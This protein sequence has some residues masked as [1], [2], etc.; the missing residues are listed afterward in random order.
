MPL[1]GR[2]EDYFDPGDLS[3]IKKIAAIGD[4]YS[5]GIGAGEALGSIIQAASP[6]SD[7]AC[8]RYAGAYP[9]YVYKDPRFGDNYPDFQFLSCSGAKIDDVLN[10]Q[11]PDLES[12]QQA[13]ML[14]VGGNDAELKNIL[15]SCVFQWGVFNPLQ[16]AVGE[17]AKL[18]ENQFK[19][20]AKYIDFEAKAR[21]CEGQLT[22]TNS[23]I[24]SNSFRS[25]LDRVLSA[26]KYKLAKGGKIYMTGYARF[27]DEAMTSECDKVTWAV[28]KFVKELYNYRQETAYLTTPRRK[29]MNVLVDDINEELA[30]AAKRA[31]DDVIFVNYDK[32]VGEFGGRFCGPGID[33]SSEGSDTRVGLMFYEPGTR[34]NKDDNPWKRSLGDPMND[35]FRGQVNL[36]VLFQQVLEPDV[37]WKI[38]QANSATAT[39]SARSALEKRAFQVPD[40]TPDAYGR[41][42]HPQILL[43]QIISNLVMWHMMDVNAVS[44]GHQALPEE[45][46]APDS[47]PIGYDGGNQNTPAPGDSDAPDFYARILPLGASIVWGVGSSNGNGFR[48]PLRD[49][50]RQAGWKVNMNVEAKSGDRVDE[51]QVKSRSSTRFQP[52]IIVINAGTNDCD[53]NHDIPGFAGRYNA[54]LDELYDAI[55]GV[56]II[57][58]T[59]LPSCKASIAANRDAVNSQIKQLVSARRSKKEKIVLADAENPAGYFTTADL[60]SD[61]IHPHDSGHRKFAG[62]LGRAIYEAKAAG[63]L[64]KPKDTGISD[65]A[66]TIDENANHCEKTYGSGVSHGPFNTQQGN[67]LDDGLYTHKSTKK[68][69]L[70]EFVAPSG[71]TLNFARFTNKFGNHDLVFIGQDDEVDKAKG[72]PYTVHRNNGEG[73]DTE[74]T[75]F[76]MSDACKGR[77]VRFVDVNADGLDDMVCIGQNGDAFVSINQGKY[78]FKWM[79]DIWKKNEGPKQDRVRLPDI[80]GDG[81]ADYCTIADNGDTTC[82][83]NGGQGDMPEYWQPL[84]VMFLG[85]GKG[86]IAGVRFADLNGDS[87]DDWMWV[88]DT[89]KTWTYLNNRKCSKN[90][91]KPQWRP[92]TGDNLSGLTHA[93][94]GEEVGRNFIQFARVYGDPQDFG[95]EGRLDY[96]WV[97]KGTRQIPSGQQRWSLEVWKNEGSGA[98]KLKADGS[99]YC[100]MMGHKNGAMDYVWVHSTGYTVL[101]ESLGGQFPDDPPYWGPNREIWRAETVWG[102]K[103]DRRDLHLADWDGDGLCDIIYVRPDTN[104]M[105]VWLN[106]YKKN[107]DFGFW[108]HIS[109]TGPTG[110]YKRCEEHRGV[111]IFDLAVRFADIDGDGRADYLC[112]EPNGRVWGYLNKGDNKL[113]LQSQIKYSEGKDRA[114]LRWADVD[115][116]GKADMLWVDKF[117]GDAT[118][119][120]NKGQKPAS[121]STFTWELRGKAYMGAAQGQCEHW[122]DL[123]GDGRA[124][125]HVVDSI[126]NTAQTW[127]NVCPGGGSTSNGD[128]DDTLKTPPLTI[129]GY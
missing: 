96:I 71:F 41:V 57:A 55:P 91:L 18:F 35:T 95:L 78:S 11:I 37:Q 3:H 45:L 63:F 15:N 93:G 34:E 77:G 100:N 59:V 48:K 46:P 8:S 68:G 97:K 72:R 5:A 126:T 2:D 99:R 40:I 9:Y 23:I 31:G 60:T 65:D 28:W 116:D 38:D 94:M 83:R 110:S 10:D 47:C 86:D 67:G 117:D 69:S 13:I 64:S 1:L 30:A 129:P 51:I 89:G 49:G 98:T 44:N 121:G 6:K 53:Q 26:A 113:E 104:T 127:F 36:D 73:W 27:W 54:M 58:S 20:I 115:G 81:R 75:T 109:N 87:R 112:I 29:L 122:P 16:A 80:D 12:G 52:N 102:D 32:Y 106:Q 114:N 111:G 82:W 74:S 76:W 61:C 120:Y 33:E 42:F 24:T 25:K 128:D 125:M 101:Y 108:E 124:D 70:F 105:E 90:T 43:H 4:S 17:I 50:L 19:D 92:A 103:I 85:Q 119:W 62:V 107:G 118:V 66:G 14:S 79:S 7:W 123:D 22:Y 84:G 56:T 39:K 88:D 21:G